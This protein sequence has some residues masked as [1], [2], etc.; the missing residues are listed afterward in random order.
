MSNI[1]CLNKNSTDY[2]FEDTAGRS[3]IG[4]EQSTL[5]AVKAYSVGDLFWY[6][7]SLYKVTAAI[8]SGGTITI[9][10]NCSQTT[11][12]DEIQ[13][14]SGGASNLSDLSD[15]IGRAHV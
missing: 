7:D 4:T 1:N 11:V 3:L 13:N 9:G 5:T 8:A 10:T 6:N 2:M 12:S 14:T 15:E